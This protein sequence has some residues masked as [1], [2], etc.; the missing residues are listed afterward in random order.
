MLRRRTVSVKA[1]TKN[2]V[3]TAARR[4]EKVH[5]WSVKVPAIGSVPIFPCTV[6]SITKKRRLLLKLAT[7]S[8]II[9]GSREKLLMSLIV[10]LSH[11]KKNP[12]IKPLLDR[13]W[14]IGG[15]MI[16]PPSE[17]PSLDTKSHFRKMRINGR[18]EEKS[19]K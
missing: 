5:G 11:L 12:Y 15:N 7:V 16:V 13:Y 9:N 14:F 17:I 3:V 19:N 1:R 6:Y 2:E 18:E 10:L 4:S 8:S